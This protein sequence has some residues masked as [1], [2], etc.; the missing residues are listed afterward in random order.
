MHEV[1]THEARCR[2]IMAN[3]LNAE[4]SELALNAPQLPP[5]CEL[6]FGPYK[7][8]SKYIYEQED[9]GLFY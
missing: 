4:M 7:Q 1:L 6:T 2:H 8:I 5:M 3:F 9:R